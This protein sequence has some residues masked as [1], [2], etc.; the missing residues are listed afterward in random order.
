M[1]YL[2]IYFVF[3][4]AYVIVAYI[5]L[6]PQKQIY[7]F[8]NIFIVPILLPRVPIFFS[9]IQFDTVPFESLQVR[10]PHRETTNG[11]CLEGLQ[12]KVI[13]VL[14]VAVDV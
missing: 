7:K 14:R 12:P 10:L 3:S 4:R 6:G 13:P 2:V 8:A 1:F 11:H 5:N 9:L